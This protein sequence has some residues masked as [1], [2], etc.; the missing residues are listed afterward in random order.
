MTVLAQDGQQALVKNGSSYVR[1]HPCWHQLIPSS[2]RLAS[3]TQTTTAEAPNQ[4]NTKLTHCPTIIR[5][6][7]DSSSQEETS[8]S[9]DEQSDDKDTKDYQNNSTIPSK[10]QENRHN[11]YH[12]TLVPT[13]VKPNITIEY[14]LWENSPW[15]TVKVLLRACKA[16]Q[17]YSNC[18]NT[19]NHNNFKQPIDF[20]KIAAW[21]IVE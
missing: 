4:K 5:P 10:Q 12:K 3:E 20:S 9:E 8:S 18:W 11:R 16:T 17:N 2:P 21:K 19:M 14:K 6:Q 1:F 13:K 7:T 15:E